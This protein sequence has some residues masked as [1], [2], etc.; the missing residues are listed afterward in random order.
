M[1]KLS[2]KR[3]L[4]RIIPTF[5]Y[6]KRQRKMAIVFWTLKS[7][8]PPEKSVFHHHHHH[9]HT[10][11][12]A[13]SI[14]VVSYYGYI[15]LVH[16]SIWEENATTTNTLLPFFFETGTRKTDEVKNRSQRWQYVML[17]PQSII[18]PAYRECSENA[19]KMCI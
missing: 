10:T 9:H 5:R 13:H 7:D 8:R 6:Y 16:S 1:S 14:S 2:W 18:Y 4:L 15:H 11:P 3:H 17:Y 19:G 12:P